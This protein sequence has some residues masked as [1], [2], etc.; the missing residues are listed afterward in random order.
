MNSIFRNINLLKAKQD[1]ILLSI[2]VLSLAFTSRNLFFSLHGDEHTYVTLANSILDGSYSIN[3]KPSVVSPSVPIIIVFF[4]LFTNNLVAIYLS[5]LFHLALV[6][7]G[8]VFWFKTFKKVKLPPTIILS[9]IA[10]TLI[11]PTS[12]SWFAKLYP[13]AL[14]FFSFSGFIYYFNS[15]LLS[16]NF[17]FLLFFFLLLI[18]TRYVFAVLGLLIFVRYIE[19]LKLDFKKNIVTLSVY[20]LIAF[21]PVALWGFYLANVQSQGVSSIS[22]FD[23]FN[24]ENPIIYNLKCGLGLEQHYEVS[25]INGI[26]AFVSLFI[27]ITGFRNYLL[28]VLLI[29][30]F[31]SGYVG[32]LK[33]RVIKKILVSI[34]LI[35]TGYVF[36]GTGFSRYWVSMLPGFLLGYYLL[37]KK[38]KL[39]DKLFLYIVY[40]I[41]IVYILNEIR[42]SLLLFTSRL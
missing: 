24:I 32:T 3:E 26:P 35:M 2:I 27:P 16:K 17:A 29:I 21:I 18:F 42:I 12:I 10:L 15:D 33:P 23:R 22:Y 28:S 41:S 19:Y 39:S 20:I 7:F 38:F 1:Y 40:S 30:A 14:L 34:S 6:L 5:K 36:A 11:N 9:L 13:E 31:V 25:R 37:Y 4:K 8:C